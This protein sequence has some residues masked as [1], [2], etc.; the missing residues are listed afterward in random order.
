MVSPK[1]LFTLMTPHGYPIGHNSHSFV[2]KMTKN[3][4]KTVFWLFWAISPENNGPN[5]L[6]RGLFLSSDIGQDI[7]PTCKTKNGTKTSFLV[8]LDNFPIRMNLT[9]WLGAYVKA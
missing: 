7:L 6:V 9:I 5:D 3:C 2:P 8:V 1:V 4:C